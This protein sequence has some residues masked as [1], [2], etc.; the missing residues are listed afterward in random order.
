MRAEIHQSARNRLIVI[1]VVIAVFLG[2]TVVLAWDAFSRNPAVRRLAYASAV[3]SPDSFSC[4]WTEAA[5]VQEYACAG[6][7]EGPFRLSSHLLPAEQ[8]APA[9]S[10]VAGWEGL[11]IPDT[12]SCQLRGPAEPAGMVPAERFDCSYTHRGVSKNAQ[13]SRHGVIHTHRFPLSELVLVSVEGDRAS[14]Q[15]TRWVLPH[16]KAEEVK[17]QN[18]SHV[19]P[20]CVAGS[21]EV[22]TTRGHLRGRTVPQAL[23]R[24]DD[25]DGIGAVGPDMAIAPTGC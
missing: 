17:K 13:D 24:G 4:H 1:S 20:H 14:D 5:P 23:L 7:T 9:D 25:S 16:P 15:D 18:G 11:A 2:L 22:P 12:F 21:A 6:S 3:R 8:L 10:T 19:A